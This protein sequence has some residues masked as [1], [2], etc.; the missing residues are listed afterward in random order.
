MNTW[1]PA[2]TWLAVL[3]LL[4]SIPWAQSQVTYTDSFNTNANYLT[5]GLTG[6]IWDGVYFGAG[7][8][9]NTGLGGGGPGATVQCDANITA[10]NT[11]TLQTTGTAW[12]NA[13]D[14]GFYLFKV[15]PGDF[16][17]SVHVVSPFNNAA[18][19]TAGLQARA[20]AAGGDPYGGSENFV[21]WTRFDEYN[22]ANYLRSEVNGGV[23][24]INPGDYP[25]TN[26]W[27]RIDRVRGTNFLFYQKATKTGAWQLVSFPA[28]VSG[29]VLTR[30]DLAGLPLQV[31]IIHATFNGQLGVQF[32][33]FNLTESNVTFATAPSPATGLTVVTNAGGLNVTWQPGSG[34]AGSLVVMWPGTNSPVKEMP[35][36]GFTY[37]GNANYGFG[38]T[39]PAANYFVVYNGTGTNVSVANLVPNTTYNVAVFSFSGSGSTTAYSHSPA[40]G[41]LTLLP[42]QV[43]AQVNVQNADV[44]VTFSAN[45]GKWY[46][47]QYSD[48]LNP[49][50]WQNVVPGPVLATGS[51]LTIVH[52]GGAS[53]PQRFYR[54]QQLDP[55]F[56][57]KT[58][59]GTGSGGITSLQ[60]TGDA[61]TTEYI[62]GGK[63]GNVIMRYEP[64]GGATWSSV[65]TSVP[66]GIASATNYTSP[67]GTQYISHYVITSGLTGSFVLE[68]V[69]TFQQDGLRWSLNLTNLSSQSVVVGDLALPLPMN[70]GFSGITSSAM[71]H[72]LI[73]GSDSFLFWMRPDS[74]GPYLLMTPDDQ[75]KLEYWDVLNGYEVYVHS[76]VAA[77]NAATQYPTVTTQGQRWRQ[78]NTSLTLAAGASQ[79]YGFNFQWA[80]N[81]DAIR[82]D[83]VDNG[84][85]DVHVV[86][87]MTVPTNLFAEIAL[88]TTQQITGV[89]AEFPSQTQIQSLGN[90]GTY[91]LYRVQFSQSGENE[92][93]VQYGA[94]QTMYLEFFVTEPLET[95]IKKRAAFLVSHQVIT[96]KWYSGLFCDLNMNDGVMVTPDNHDTLD[97]SFQVYEIASDDA[98]ESRPA[99]LAT[100]EAVYPV[101]SEVSALDY[102]ITNFVWGGL[103][104]A[105]NETYSYGIY[106]VPDWYTLRTNNNLSIGRGYDYPHIIV[107]YYEMYRLAKYHP[108]ITT[109]LSADTYLQRAWGTAMALWSYGGGQATQVGLMNEVVIPDLIDALNAEGMTSQ[110]TSLKTDWETKVSYYV[111]GNADLFA[112]EYAFDSTGFESQEA[113]AKYA[114]QHAG[115]DALM[116][117]GNPSAFLQQVQQYQ[118]TEITANVFDRGWLET[119]YYDYGSDYRGDMGNDYI[120]TY[121][122]QMG[123]WGLLDYALYY[124]TNAT[125]YLRLGYGSYLNGWS[126]MNSGPP[127]NYGFWYPGAAYDGGCGGGF[128]PSPY[129]TTWLGGQPMHRGPWYYSAEENLGFCG[130][131]R[132]AATILADDPI[133]GRFCYGG[134]WQQTTNIQVIPLDGV[135]R[136]FH[137]MF[138]TGYL[139]LVL[140]NDRFA[141]AQPIVLQPDLS[142]VSF[143]IES[144]N[145]AAHSVTLHFTSS[146][147]ATYTFSS[148]HGAITTTNLLAGQEAV[149][150]LPK[151]AGSSPQSFN[152]SR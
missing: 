17:M 85:I 80:T 101:Q 21:S 10:V 92:L 150:S 32:T 104:R 127:P 79:T 54:L 38:S 71:Q 133:F 18:Y 142:Q 88:N 23:A 5:N 58:S 112:S 52:A 33:D 117:S 47:L 116:G 86:P 97:S 37:T 149:V 138:D 121:M 63:L 19:N 14:D 77:A 124:A 42:N 61:Y 81:Y 82:Q 119:A 137:A 67:D 129:N 100:K 83:L 26:Y 146:T 70:T 20:F 34:S 107:M 110:A 68:S 24:Q 123:G 29:T 118:N 95:L 103:Q 9:N 8:F 50:N 7:E 141:A 13:D 40:T 69:F 91:Q 4:A 74:V 139:H 94:G 147:A 2:K 59:S 36:N 148:I 57:V 55:E 48:S 144:E 35:A 31:G 43:Y 143:Q 30:P 152:I 44:S 99:Y 130:A 65:Y 128:E 27:L 89:T 98:G 115:S 114:L 140:D 93:T 3:G 73:S 151:D 84:K 113:Y 109:A 60:R 15:V 145:T 75:T 64:S 72:F 56:A 6:T 102:Y 49:A 16:S 62:S 46:W 105:T 90:N 125:D 28:P 12:E 136:R 96:N 120:V 22:F 134:T 25:N 87:G 45:P 1:Q 39:L 126:T 108:E 51:L 132:M 106:G 122:A 66:S 111:N 78:P 131:V 41:S 11:L 76:A 53:A 135:R